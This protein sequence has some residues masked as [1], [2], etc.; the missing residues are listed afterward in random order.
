M[1][2]GAISQIVEKLEEKGLV[3]RVRTPDNKKN[4]MLELTGF[5]K[6]AFK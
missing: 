5:G 6:E 2:R 1:T 4:I 3:K